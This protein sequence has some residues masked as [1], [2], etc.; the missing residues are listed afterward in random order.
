MGAK[1]KPEWIAEVLLRG[2]R[3]RDY[4]DAAMPQFGEA[5]VGHLV[6]LFGKV[7]Q[8]GSGDV[9]QDCEHSASPRNA[10]YEMIGT[11]GFSCI[12]CH[13]FNGQKAGGAGALDIVNVTERIKKSWFHLYMRQPSRFH[14]TVIMPSYWPGGQSIRPTILGGDTAQQIEALWAYLEDGTRAKKPAGL[15]R[16][17]NELRVGDRRGNLPWS[18]HRGL[19]WNWRRLSGAHQPCIRFGGDGVA[20]AFVEG[21]VRE[22]RSSV[23]FMRAARI[24]FPSQ[25]VFRF[26]RLKSFDDHWPYKGKTNYT[27]PQDHGYQFRGY[28]L[29]ALRR[30][31]FMYRYGDIAVEDFFEDVR[32]KDGTAFFRRTIQ[33]DAPEAQQPFHFRAASGKKITMTSAQT[34]TVDALLLHITSAHRAERRKGDPGEVLIPLTLPKGRSTLVLEY[35]W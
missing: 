9:P 17:S 20:P 28:R 27:F 24:G 16:Q 7:D 11:T 6:E 8:A 26:H 2:K 14:P 3:Q 1:L 29:D 10:G 13:D 19:P 21:R 23:P 34:I 4:L 30:P 35:Q 5:N 33:F 31:T 32:G 22:C 12:A 15:S 25:R 18:G